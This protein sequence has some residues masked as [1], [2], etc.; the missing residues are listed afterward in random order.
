MT[1]TDSK[2]IPGSTSLTDPKKLTFMVAHRANINGLS[3]V[4]CRPVIFADFLENLLRIPYDEQEKV[5]FRVRDIIA[6]RLKNISKT[7]LKNNVK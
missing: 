6:E 2:N 7:N 5:T 4:T 1:D 3:D